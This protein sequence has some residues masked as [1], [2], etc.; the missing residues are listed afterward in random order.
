MCPKLPRA[1]MFLIQFGTK[2]CARNGFGC[3]VR[4]AVCFIHTQ[5]WPDR[6]CTPYIFFTVYLVISLPEILYIHRISMVLADPIHTT[7]LNK[8]PYVHLLL[9]KV[10]DVTRVGQDHIY[11]W[12]VRGIFG[13]EIT[14]Y[15][16]K[17]GVYTQFWP[18]LGTTQC[19]H[20]C[21]DSMHACADSQRR[22][23]MR[24][25]QEPLCPA[26]KLIDAVLVYHVFSAC[27]F[28]CAK[29]GHCV[30]CITRCSQIVVYYY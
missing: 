19:E 20:A 3:P 1:C 12:Y 27:Y 24:R 17:Y 11:I 9:V 13:R 23:C 18:T 30:I 16:V 10:E 25:R 8:R 14:K 6:I 29:A 4:E 26:Y 15:T 2:G 7:Y 28:M 5:G 21:T 22:P